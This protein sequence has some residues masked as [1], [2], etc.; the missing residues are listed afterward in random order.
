M[1]ETIDDI[2]EDITSGNAEDVTEEVSEENTATDEVA[3][4]EETTTPAEEVVTPTEE[5]NIP[6][7]W[8]APIKDFFGSDV[9]KDNFE[10]KK[11]FFDKF[12][13]MD[14]GYQ[15]KYQTL[16]D[17]R[18]E[19]E[20]NQAGFEDNRG[21]VNN[22]KA[23]EE[24][25]RAIDSDLFNREVARNGGTNQYMMSLHQVNSMMEKNP[26]E[27]ISNICQAYQITPEMLTNGQQDPQYQ[28][29]QTQASTQQSMAELK[30]EVLNEFR[31]EQKTNQAQ[32]E[33]QGLF[34]A[35]DDSGNLK[36][37]QLETIQGDVGLLMESKGLNLDEA[38][39]MAKLM[40]PAAFTA[41]LAS[42]AAAQAKA[43]EVA[44]AK[45]PKSIKASPKSINTTTKNMSYDDITAEIMRENGI[46]V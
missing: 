29:R 1:N 34:T 40:N 16:A 11:A 36:Y 6:E 28:A 27:T 24:Q 21:L 18:K 25:G 20:A 33:Y 46:E 42:Q 26:L 23:L 38:Y 13:S 39:N 9:F 2:I 45:A 15:G 31:E 4:I 12:K 10:A 17:E 30:Q 37:P 41:E 44:R 14:D 5:L 35:T 43:E 3:P 7:N 22:Y 32:Q 8:E 19:F